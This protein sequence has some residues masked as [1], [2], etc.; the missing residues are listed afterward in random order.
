MSLFKDVHSLL[1]KG[2]P[3]MY[4]DL[5]TEIFA[6]VLRDSDLLVSFLNEFLKLSLTN[7]QSVIIDTQKTYL[8]LDNHAT[9]SRPDLVM[10]FGEEKEKYILFFENKVES[11]EGDSQLQRYADHLRFYDA[12]GYQTYLIYITKYDDPKDVNKIFNNAV[13]GKFISL[14]WYRIYNWLKISQDPYVNKVIDFMEEIGLSEIRRFSPQ[15]IYALQEISRLQHMMDECLDGAVDEVMTSLFEKAIGWS[16]RAVQLRDYCRYYKTNDQG[17]STWIGCG[18]HFTEEE[19]PLICIQYEVSP[20]CKQRKTVIKAMND[21]LVN[22]QEWKGYD[23]DNDSIW[24]GISCDKTLLEFLR[25]EDHIISIQEYFI[26]KLKEL[27]VLKQ[28]NGG[29]GWK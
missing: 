5:L 11:P 23:L 28:Q 15:D 10:Q 13:F 19:Y 26:E 14:R 21:F 27:H 29:L 18:F 25:E 17:N 20:T 3:N 7:P 16:N 24:S 1:R 2:Q 12:E 9:D 6:D 4:E 22:N 8:K